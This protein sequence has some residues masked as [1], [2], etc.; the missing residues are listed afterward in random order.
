MPSHHDPLH[1]TVIIQ[2]I[3]LVTPYLSKPYPLVAGCQQAFEDVSGK[4]S[5]VVWYFI[6]EGENFLVEKR[7]VGILDEG[8][9][10]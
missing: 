4:G 8:K 2:P 5:D 6:V 3:K 10:T 9:A 1:S 7:G